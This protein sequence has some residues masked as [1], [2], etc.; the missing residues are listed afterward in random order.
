MQLNLHDLSHLE[1]LKLQIVDVQR[2][3]NLD[4]VKMDIDVPNLKILEFGYFEYDFDIYLTAPKLEML[5]YDEFQMTTLTYPENVVHLEMEIQNEDFDETSLKELQYLKVNFGPVP[6]RHILSA[7]PKLTTLVCNEWFYYD[8]DDYDDS[9]NGLRELVEQKRILKRHDLKIY[10]HSVEMVDSSK[11]DELMSSR[12]IL[13]FQM[14]NYDSLCDNIAYGISLEYNELMRLVNGKLP[15]DFHQKFINLQCVEVTEE[16][17]S[18]EHLEQFL[19]SFDYLNELT[20]EKTW[21]DQSFYDRL[22]E[23][24]QLTTLTVKMSLNPIINYDFLFKLKHLK[25]F[26]TDRR[27][28]CFPDFSLAL[29]KELKDFDSINFYFDEEY[30]VIG[31]HYITNKYEFRR[32]KDRRSSRGRKLI[33]EKNEM[34]FDE[35]V[36]LVKDFKTSKSFSSNEFD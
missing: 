35:L 13:A 18:F 17:K 8:N 22:P 29:F 1:Q 24:G 3:Y 16:V 5:K 27:F 28:P 6:S 26:W 34:N 11:I 4:G 33:Y 25:N 10:Y 20:L 14:N 31:K 15:Q 23:I 32:L 9:M 7:Y 21:L 12:S 2:R 36:D 30:I 19:T